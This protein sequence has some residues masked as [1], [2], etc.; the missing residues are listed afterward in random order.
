MAGS[1]GRQPLDDLQK[2]RKELDLYDPQLSERPW[3]V[4]ANKMDLPD[5]KDRLKDFRKRYKK[6]EIIPISA[7]GGEGI[8]ALKA[9]IGTLVL[10]QESPGA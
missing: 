4:V 8:A 2:L 7:Q 1:E 10:R 6:I 3:I 5:A 9:R